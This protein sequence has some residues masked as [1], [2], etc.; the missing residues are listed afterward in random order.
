MTRLEKIPKYGSEVDAVYLCPECKEKALWIHDLR[1]NICDNFSVV[2]CPK[3]EYHF[4]V[5]YD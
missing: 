2:Y 4:K 3:C 5:K 1:C